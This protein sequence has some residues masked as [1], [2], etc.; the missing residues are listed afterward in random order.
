MLILV[1][2]SLGPVEKEVFMVTEYIIAYDGQPVNVICIM[3]FKLDKI[4]RETI[5]FGDP[6]Q[7][8]ELR[9]KWIEKNGK[10]Q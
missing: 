3:E 4:V 10:S 9:D 2:V 5:Y 1:L 8:Q 7:P 6:F